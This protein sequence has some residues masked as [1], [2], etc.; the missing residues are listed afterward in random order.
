MLVSIIIITLNEEENLKK[1]IESVKKA[2]KLNNG[3]LLPIEIIVSDGGSEDKTVEIA[4]VLADKVIIGPRGRY[5]QL[6]TGAKVSNGD[7]LLFLHA[8]TLL[9]PDAI[10]MIINQMSDF[11]VFGGGF[12]KK[13][14]WNPNVQLTSFLK[15]MSYMWQGFGIW[16]VRLLKTFPGDNAIF[17]RK[18]IFQKLN[19]FSALW[20]CEDFDFIKRLKKLGRK[21]VIF[22]NSAV[23][24]STRRYEKYGFFKINIIWFFIYFTWR[25]GMPS[26]RLR[27]RFKKYSIIPKRV[28]RLIIRF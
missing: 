2:A 1:T 22:I 21:H 25:F 20:I 7:I 4:N 23:L 13:W 5:K 6:N 28:N 18:S 10:L 3:S 17:V 24:T 27:N 15:F 19:G 11:N 9:P 14:N 26:N 8:D 12:K 16:L